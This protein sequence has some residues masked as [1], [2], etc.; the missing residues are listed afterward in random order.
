MTSAFPAPRL[1]P[2]SS[3][4]VFRTL[5]DAVSHPGRPFSLDLDN[6]DDIRVGD[7]RTGDLPMVAL[8]LLSLADID[9]TVAVVGVDRMTDEHDALGLG[10]RIARSTGARLTSDVAAADLVLAGAGTTSGDLLALR[11][12]NH[13]EPER[14]AKLFVACDDIHVAASDDELRP[15]DPVLYVRVT[16]PGASDGRIVGLAGLDRTVLEFVSALNGSFP[17]GV[18]AWVVAPDGTVVAIPRSCSIGL[19]QGAR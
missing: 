11:V 16:G 2:E 7:L 5:L 15:D 14:G 6:G 10:R 9:V 18:D 12:G 8:P 19:A 1:T 13:H 4:S 17:A 3:L